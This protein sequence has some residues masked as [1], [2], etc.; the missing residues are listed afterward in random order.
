MLLRWSALAP[1]AIRRAR[2]MASAPEPAAGEAAAAGFAPRADR[3]AYVRAI[4]AS[5]DFIDAGETY[6]VCLTNQLVRGER[7]KNEAEERKN[8]ARS[9]SARKRFPRRRPGGAVLGAPRHEPGALRRGRASAG[10]KKKTNTK[11]NTNRIRRLFPARARS[12]TTTRSTAATTAAAPGPRDAT[13]DSYESPVS[14]VGEA[15]TNGEKTRRED[16][17]RRYAAD[18]VLA[19]CC[20]SPERFLRLSKRGNTNPEPVL[21]AKPIKGTARRHDPP[22][23]AADIAEAE[24]LAARGKVRAENEMN[25]ELQRNDRGCACRVRCPSRG[26]RRSRA[27][28][29]CTSW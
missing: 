24:A 23:C 12:S 18:D 22:G 13:N 15:A 9:R 27:T 8:S 1:D 14:G 28:P 19:V 25:D 3:D 21:E 11:T 16:K 10:A 29:P 4:V 26:S 20:C 5:Q 6:E 7:T 2:A 17:T